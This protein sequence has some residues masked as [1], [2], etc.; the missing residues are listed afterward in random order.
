[1]KGGKAIYADNIVT[2]LLE[3]HGSGMCVLYDNNAETHA[4]NT[5]A[6]NVGEGFTEVKHTLIYICQLHTIFRVISLLLYF[7]LCPLLSH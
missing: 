7:A 4:L 5:V 3:R 6:L 2:F 1:M